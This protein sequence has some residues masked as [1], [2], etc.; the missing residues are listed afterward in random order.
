MITKEEFAATLDGRSYREEIT[1]EECAIADAAG[2]VVIFGASDDL[3]EFRGA[4]DDEVGVGDGSV[5][6]FTL[7]GKI[8]PAE[9]DRSARELLERHGVLDIVEKYRAEA[10]AIEVINEA[11][12]TYGTDVPHAFFRIT[13]DGQAFCAGMVIDLHEVRKAEGR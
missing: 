5:V 8:L 10:I 4:I 12:W 1:L 11:P 13:E 6:R 9:I 2:L 3:M 7:S